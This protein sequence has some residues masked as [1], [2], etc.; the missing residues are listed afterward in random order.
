MPL[1]K[2][3]VLNRWSLKVQFEAEIDCA[4]DT[5]LRVKMGLAVR[6]ACERD[7]DLRGADL[8]GAVLRDAD[9]RDAD[10]RGAVL[11]DADLR[12]ADLR[13][14]DLRGSDLRGAVLRGAVLSGAVLSDAV[15]SDAVLSDAV[16]RDADL[17]DADLRGA[18]LRGAVL[19]D[20]D[21][22]GA[23]LS[24]AVLSDAVLSDAVL[25]GSDLRGVPVVPHI[26]A[27]ILRAI[28]NGGQ[29]DMS[30]WHR[31]E[32]THCRAGWAI[33][34]AGAAGAALEFAMGSAGA[35]AL[36]YAASRPGK[37]VPN[38]Y[39]DNEMALADL[40]EGAEADPLPVEVK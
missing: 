33:T 23:V 15:L 31:C 28:E 39:A 19:R 34:L 30:T 6:W 35:G 9:L 24:G 11:R 1:I 29:L 40:R 20:A 38:F 3:P 5:S 12:D 4:E 7:A 22:R 17:R 10:L 8:R 37:P 2:F 36:I 21:L 26:D 32:T 13:D 16:L 27:A 25:R 14:A 18:V